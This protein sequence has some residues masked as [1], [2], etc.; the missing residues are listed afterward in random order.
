MAFQ[1]I[2]KFDICDTVGLSRP[3]NLHTGQ[4]WKSQLIVLTY[5]YVICGKL[6]FCMDGVFKL[7]VSVKQLITLRKYI[8]IKANFEIIFILFL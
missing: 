4:Q 5:P 3:Q 6:H 8:M 7:F 2:E 1:L